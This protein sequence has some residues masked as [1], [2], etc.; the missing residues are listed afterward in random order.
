LVLALSGTGLIGIALVLK[1]EVTT[2][3]G[4]AYLPHTVRI[5]DVG[6]QSAPIE[7]LD[8]TKALL[9]STTAPVRPSTVSK[10]FIARIKGPL[11]EGG[12]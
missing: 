9:G 6:T 3:D 7:V 8:S 10:D 5:E 4:P 11:P 1:A 2:V 12:Q